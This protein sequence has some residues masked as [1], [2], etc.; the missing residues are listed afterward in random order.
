MDENDLNKRVGRAIRHFWAV[1]DQ[2]ARNQGRSSGTR[3]AGL[4][5]A[6]T[7]GKHLD[8]FVTLCRDLLIESGLPEANVHWTKG[9][10]ELPGYFRAE[11][12]WDLLA[13]VEGKL[14]AVV[15]FKVT[16]VCPFFIAK[17][18]KIEGS[19]PFEYGKSRGRG[20]NDSPE[21]DPYE[22]NTE[23]KTNLQADD[24][25]YTTPDSIA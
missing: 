9:H 17:P 5:T 19:K 25:R 4:R 12:S 24:C 22:K 15:E 6:V 20:S 14:L 21:A 10:L 8:G 11:K 23:G 7:G 2:Q 13:V 3:D 16:V 1:R 18:D